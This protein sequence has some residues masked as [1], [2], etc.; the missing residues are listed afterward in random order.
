MCPLTIHSY[1]WYITDVLFGRCIIWY[2]AQT[3]TSRVLVLVEGLLTSCCIPAAA[4]VILYTK[5]GYAIKF[6]YQDE[7]QSSHTKRLTRAQLNIF[8]TCVIMVSC[9]LVCWSFYFGTILSAAVKKGDLKILLSDWFYIAE[10]LLEVN[11]AIN[12]IIY[13]LR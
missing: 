3:M 13:S 5:M 7:K 1:H 4:I 12:P 9:F 2:H 6:G 8:S 10:A 11:S